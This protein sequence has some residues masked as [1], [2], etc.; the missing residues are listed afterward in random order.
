MAKPTFVAVVE[1]SSNWGS[2]ADAAT[3][4]TSSFS[5]L[6]GDRLIVC[7]VSE[8]NTNALDTPPVGGSL[9]WTADEN[10]GVNDTDC[11]TRI[12]SAT[13]DSDKS[14]TVAVT[15]S[16]GTGTRFWGFIVY[17]F[18]G[19]DGFGAAESTT[20]SGAPSLSITTTQANSAVIAINGD[21]NAVDGT[22][23]TWRT[24]N[25]ITPTSGNGLEKSY[26]RNS[27]AYGVYSAYWDDAGTAAAK[28]VGLSAP[29]SQRFGICAIE[30][31]GSSAGGTQAITGAL[32]TDAD[33]F[34]GATVGRGAVDIGGA[35][36]AN[37]NSFFASTVSATYPITGALVTDADTFYGATI[38][39]GA[40]N[41]SGALFSDG[42]TFYGAAITTGAVDISGA[43]FADADVFYA[44][45][46]SQGGA[47][48]DVTGA[49]EFEPAVQLP[50]RVAE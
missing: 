45:T 2:T 32:V 22:T 46:V 50:Q 18:R 39:A 15:C 11:D 35:L 14:M 29:G 20:G 44:S 34:Y 17:Q 12:W 8:N 49:L 10:I 42:D 24:V 13:V 28:T 47:P 19:S 36:F 43:L 6:A 38:A 25:S 37:A 40:V 26:F 30:V 1:P 23:R 48:Q 9:T 16:G 3:R 7:A 27:A 33:T 21:F 41:I 5:V 4:T 31:K